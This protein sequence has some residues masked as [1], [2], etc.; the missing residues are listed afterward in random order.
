MQILA[1]IVNLEVLQHIVE[2]LHLHACCF[3]WHELYNDTFHTFDKQCIIYYEVISVLPHC[4]TSIDVNTECDSRKDSH[5]LS[6]TVH[7]YSNV[8]S[9]QW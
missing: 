7:V 3:E 1:M 8:S 9:G 4:N 6:Y 2:I 5:A